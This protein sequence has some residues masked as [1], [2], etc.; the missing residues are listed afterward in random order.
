M[1][2]GTSYVDGRLRLRCT[3]CGKTNGIP[4]ARLLDGPVCGHCRTELP[5]PAQPIE[6]SDRSFASF[7]SSSPLP[8]LVDFWAPGC[9]PCV[10]LAPVVARLA[11]RHAGKILVAKLDTMANQAV[12]RKL[13]IQSVPLTMV[14]D[15]GRPINSQLGLVP[16]QVLESM[17]PRAA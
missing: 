1:A 5:M 12:A 13:G 16:E 6:L 9:G 7:V 11:E 4:I 3:A 8:V 15:G 17:L 2:T 14:F 10:A